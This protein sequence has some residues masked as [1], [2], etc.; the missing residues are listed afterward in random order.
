MSRERKEL[1][2]QGEAY[3]AAYLQA[4]GFSICAQNYAQRQGEIDI[5]A[6]KNNLLAFVEVKMR[7]TTYFPL[8]ELV[9]LSKQKK[10]I[11]TACAYI[12]SYHLTGLIYRFDVALLE[13]S[14][15]DSYTIIYLANAFTAP[16]QGA[17]LL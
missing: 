13:K 16:N 11:K 7:R 17:L 6:R 2:N 5:I 1:G 12:A 3:V 14:C 9:S 8:S 15:T 4:Q 10:I